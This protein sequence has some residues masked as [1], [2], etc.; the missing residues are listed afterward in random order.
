MPPGNVINYECFHTP[1][2]LRT[3]PKSLPVCFCDIWQVESG[4]THVLAVWLTVD[5]LH[6][7]VERWL[8]GRHHQHHMNVRTPFQ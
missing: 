4:T 8:S 5:H 2:L 1:P 3:C 6:V 7:S